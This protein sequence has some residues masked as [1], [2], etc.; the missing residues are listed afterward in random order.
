MA[1]DFAFE[2]GAADI[3]VIACGAAGR[4]LRLNGD[5]IGAFADMVERAATDAAVAGV[6]VAID[7]V[8]LDLDW[9]AA[10]T[11]RADG[12]RELAAAVKRLNAA[13]V[14][15]E[16]SAKPFVAAIAGPA[17]GLGAEIALACGARLMARHSRATIGLADVKLGL[18][19]MAGG[20][21]RLARLIGTPAARPFLVGGQA[22]TAAQA[23]NNGLVDELVTPGG[24]HAAAI[25][26][27]ADGVPAR[28]SRPVEAAT[29]RSAG[30]VDEHQPARGAIDSTLADVDADVDADPDAGVDA[31]AHAD[32]DVAANA[33]ADVTIGRALHRAGERFVDVAGGSVARAMV[34]TLGLG[35]ARANALA[36]R[37]AAAPQRSFR[38]IGVLGAGLM[39]SGIA[40]VCA[41]AGL[42]VVL[43]DVSEAAAQRG[44][45][46]LRDQEDAAIAAGRADA[47]ASRAALARIAPTDRYEALHDVDLVVEAVFE[48]RAVKAEA[49]RRAEAA[50]GAGVV[51][52]TNTSTL[53]IHGLA[54]ASAR[55][56]QFIGLHFFSP[57]PRMPLLEIIRGAATSDATLATSM[58]FA[59]A[60]AKTPIVVNDARG[61]YTTRVVMAYQAE[62]FDMLAQ[63]IAAAAVEAAGVAT[64]MPIAPLALSDAVAL[65]LIHQINV[66]ARNDLGDRYRQS[67]GYELVGRMV[68]TGGRTGKKTGRGFYDYDAA[69][70]KQLWPGLGELV[71]HAPVEASREDLRDRLLAVQALETARALEEGVIVDP[72]EADLGAILGWGFAPWTGGP[73]SYIDGQGV[74]RFVARCD[75]LQRRY[76]GERLRPTASLRRIAAAGGSVYG[77]DWAPAAARDS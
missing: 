37:P 55:P 35:V 21:I 67:P 29:S 61:F 73:L 77:T 19:P 52:A 31:P 14:R 6:V 49:T 48:D 15:I 70:G 30:A 39:G 75:E 17:L 42:D 57:V 74:A 65:D 10:T 59:Q 24:L 1:S 43:V 54:A 28:Q 47:E 60:I 63:G 16:T 11:A 33:D 76:G 25:R 71:A 4:P 44:L 32:G 72:S 26:R 40:W 20:A 64:G 36:R 62:A 38:K 34:R 8:G 12:S 41:S 2:I 18:P 69:G 22:T 9:L 68:E 5:R 45:A 50:I 3:A 53:P 13:L 58:D 51:L 23:L 66:Q 27:A 56:A 46:R 7:D